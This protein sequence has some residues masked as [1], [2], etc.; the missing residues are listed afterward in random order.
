MAQELNDTGTLSPKETDDDEI[1]LIDL[2]AVL[3]R[4]KT[5]II[6]ITLVA[7]IGVVIFSILSI[8]LPPDISPLPNEYSPQALMLINNTSSSSSGVSAM[9]NASG[10]GGLANLAGVGTTGSTVSGLAIYML[11]TNSFLDN[12]VDTFDLLTRYKIV[13]EGKKP[14]KSPRANSRKILKKKLV[15]EIDEQS[16]ILTISFTDTDPEFA[17]TVV[18]YCM[19]KLEQSFTE[20]GVDK[21]QVEKENLEINVA[22]TFR[23]IQSYER[24]SQELA[25]SVRDNGTG[26]IPAITMELNRIE[27]ELEIQRQVYTQLRVQYE[28]LKVSM[29]SEKPVFQI[30]ELAEV[31]D[32]KSGPSRGMICVIVTLAAGFFAVFL[33]FVMN[34]IANI[35]KDPEAMAKLRGVPY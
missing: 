14:P 3:W 8:V 35:K 21:N 20:M 33:A 24:Q 4:R 1:S 26:I 17:Q 2:F 12:V 23:E 15:G 32:L 34:A 5:M 19:N 13:V 18:N 31:P 6:A 9:I 10:L 28:L 27:T 29:A 7:A 30:V 11:G 16:G 22:N 25:F